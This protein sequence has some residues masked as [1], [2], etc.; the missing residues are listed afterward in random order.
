MKKALILSFLPL[1]IIGC[2]EKKKE[3][4]P[5]DTTPAATKAKVEA[6]PAKAKP[7]EVKPMTKEK[8]AEKSREVP[9]KTASKVKLISS[10]KAPQKLFSYQPK[11]GE[12]TRFEVRTVRSFKSGKRGGKAR[13]LK[14]PPT[15]IGISI[16]SDAVLENGDLQY[17]MRIIDS[18]IENVEEVGMENLQFMN[19]LF[20]RMKK[21]STKIVVKPNGQVVDAVLSVPESITYD[22][23]PLV[24][25]LKQILSIM[26]LVLP[27]KPVGQGAT[28]DVIMPFGDDS[29]DADMKFGCKLAK[30]D[31]NKLQIQVSLSEHGQAKMVQKE[32]AESDEELESFKASGDLA[33]KVDLAHLVF[34][35]DFTVNTDMAIKISSGDKSIHVDTV[36]DIKM[37]V[38]MK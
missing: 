36:A 24:G 17:T 30:V 27:D 29:V 4:S 32:G 31:N 2:Q 11:V 23:T 25:N 5:S 9:I 7:T 6:R 21:T 20:S 33:A 34:I 35:G 1:F 28:W 8:V 13:E 14:M 15:V 12:E 10:G 26:W 19:D 18:K 38:K 22:M 3:P 16:K 37:S